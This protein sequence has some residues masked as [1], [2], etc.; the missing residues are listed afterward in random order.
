MRRCS[1]I[2]HG[3]CLSPRGLSL[4][5]VIELGH[6]CVRRGVRL[7][8]VDELGELLAKCLSVRHGYR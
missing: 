5:L 3:E 4:Q 7:A 1:S 6:G 8:E 2:S